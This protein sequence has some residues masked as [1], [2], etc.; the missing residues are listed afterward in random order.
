MWQLHWLMNSAT[1]K[2][3]WLN[4]S[5]NLKTP[6]HIALMLNH[7]EFVL[8]FLQ[9]GTFFN[10]KNQEKINPIEE[11]L[12]RTQITILKNNNCVYSILRSKDWLNDGL[13]A[14]PTHVL[15]KNHVQVSSVEMYF[16]NKGTMIF[17]KFD[18]HCSLERISTSLTEGWFHFT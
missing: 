6:L 2:R 5:S 18:N 3:K 10:A 12:I 16:Q 1:S 15:C 14:T 4:F 13:V 17:S 9:N 8:L 7:G 11:V